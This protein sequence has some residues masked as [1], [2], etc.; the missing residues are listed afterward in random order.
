MRAINDFG[1]H[2]ERVWC[3]PVGDGSIDDLL[4]SDW[5]SANV[6]DRFLHVTYHLADNQNAPTASH[7]TLSWP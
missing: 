6:K 1:K 3:I 5:H 2:Q 7:S 4:R